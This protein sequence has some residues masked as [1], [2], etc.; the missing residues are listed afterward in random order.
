[1]ISCSKKEAV[2]ESTPEYVQFFKAS[3]N[4]KPMA[5]ENT[6]RKDR[7]NLSGSWTGLGFA[8]GEQKEL[9]TISVALP[10]ETKPSETAKLRIHIWEVKE[11]TFTISN[12][13]PNNLLTESHILLWKSNNTYTPNNHAKPFTVRITKYERPAGSSIPTVG[14]QLNGVLYNEQNSQDS[15]VIKDGSFEVRF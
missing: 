3:V 1:M 6:M 9:Y 4:G 11:G 12:T 8:S 14:G 7:E 10:S 2:E 15:V 5:V 13:I